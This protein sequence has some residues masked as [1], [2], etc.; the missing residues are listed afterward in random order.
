MQHKVSDETIIEDRPFS[1]ARKHLAR[2]LK[3]LHYGPASISVIGI[4]DIVFS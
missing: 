3:K 1:E 4:R 2:K